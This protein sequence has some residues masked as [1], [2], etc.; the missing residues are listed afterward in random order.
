MDLGKVW[1]VASGRE[2]RSVASRVFRNII[3]ILRGTPQEREDK[4][5]GGEK[6]ELPKRTLE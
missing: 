4:I 1:E 5:D 6:I 3:S 2:I